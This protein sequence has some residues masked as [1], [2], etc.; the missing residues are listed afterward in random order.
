M[1][2]I[3]KEISTKNKLINE[4]LN[5]INFIKNNTFLLVVTMFFTIFSYGCLLFYYRISIDGETMLSNYEGTLGWWIT[6]ERFMLVAIKRITDVNSFNTYSAT[7]LQI[8]MIFVFGVIWSY[9]VY[10]FS[11][12]N[13]FLWIFPIVFITYPTFSEQFYFVLQG[14]EVALAIS[15]SA[16]SIFFISKWILLDY[17]KIY[18]LLG[19]IFMVISFG[20]YQ[21]L[22]PL[23]ISGALAVFILYYINNNENI[24]KGRFIEIITKYIL[25]FLLGMFL[26]K[27]IGKILIKIF[28][29]V[30][31]T[32]YLSGQIQ[33][34]YNS[35]NECINNI[36]VYVKDM[37]WS[38]NYFSSKLYIV[39]SIILLICSVFYIIKRKNGAILFL[40]A[41]IS[42]L[43]SPF[44]L[45]IAFGSQTVPRAQLQFP[46]VIAIGTYVIL[47]FLEK[48]NYKIIKLITAICFCI[49]AF[50]Q[51]QITSKFFY[52]DY[53]RYQQDVALA[54]KITYKID[55]I[56]AEYDKNYPVVFIGKYEHK[57][58]SSC[59]KGEAIGASFFNWYPE[60]STWEATDR[61]LSF[62]DS[63]GYNYR[64][65]SEKEMDK[66]RMNSKNMPSWPNKDS[67]KL[68]DGII[69]VKLS[70]SVRK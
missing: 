15:L 20:T 37:I 26:Y 48:G 12:S 69:I 1:D 42:F 51:A 21:A 29:N 13:K 24:K 53:I 36:F 31:S 6:L 3:N 67:V 23:Y 40:L 65:P 44:F 11:K 64:F 35:I 47:F 18:F 2:S 7:L 33:W 39:I 60:Q 70:D 5:L 14:F 59:I 38:N 62:M 45:S 9:L 22:V 66:G 32:E 4:Y 19:I 34:K 41:N 27:L 43:I 17:D 28:R 68:E 16:V 61:V 54:N 58:P 63:L 55:E 10:Y 8:C 46:L 30:E 57:L 52:S 25:S 56:Q 50:H 49:V